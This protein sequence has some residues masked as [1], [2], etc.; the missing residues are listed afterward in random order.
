[1]ANSQFR[2]K[3]KVSGKRYVALRK[4]RLNELSG[5]SAETSIDKK[6]IKVKRTLG[7]NSKT[8]LLSNDEV[9]VNKEDK[10]LKLKIIGVEE[11]P[12]NVNFTRRNII[13]KGAIIKT[14]KGNVQ[15]TSRPGQNA[16]LFGKLI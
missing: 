6:R 11:N 15:I 13:T 7:G 3:R 8:Q 2:S 5:L 9:L 10:V 14:E 16:N 1:M 4:K 12:A